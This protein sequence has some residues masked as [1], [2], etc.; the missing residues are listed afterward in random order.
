MEP[1]IQTKNLSYKTGKI[2]ILDNINFKVAV[3]EELTIAGPSGSGKST[4]LK[5]IASLITQTSGEVLFKG[6]NTLDIAPIKYRRRVSYCV[7][8][9][10][11][12]G[13]TVRDNLVFPY[14]IRKQEINEKQ[15]LD[16]LKSVSLDKSYLDRKID[17]ISG[18]ERQ[19]V[20]MIR[21]ILFKPDV[22]LLDEVTTGLDN[23]SKDI[24]LNLIE[25][26]R[27]EGTTIIQITHDNERIKN[28]EHLMIIKKGRV[29]QNESHSF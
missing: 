15:I 5:T 4:L 29:D 9:P 16:A 18:G 1:I 12:F 11:L 27:Q 2:Q 7:Q 22:L 10:Q 8:Q 14:Q 25:Q 24:V 13:D 28:A 23:I 19:R 6:K 3:S 26:K 21:N 20:A 17:D